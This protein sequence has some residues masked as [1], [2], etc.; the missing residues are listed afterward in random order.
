MSDAALKIVGGTKNV[1]DEELRQWL[2]DYVK[3]HPHLNTKILSRTD[4]IGFS[5]TG[6][7]AY[8]KGTYFLSVAQGGAGVNPAESNLEKKIRAYREKVGE[9]V[10][11]G[12]KKSY[13]ETRLRQTRRG[14]ITS[15]AAIQNREINHDAD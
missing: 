3:D 11:D 8:I 14:Q 13:L 10:I 1:G 5:R 4:H 12:V 6:L 9:V 15:F 2:E 7:D